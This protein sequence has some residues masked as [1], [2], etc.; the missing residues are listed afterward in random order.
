MG[1]YGLM[2][3][4]SGLEPAQCYYIQTPTDRGF[5]NSTNLVTTEAGLS[6][7][8]IG[9]TLEYIGGHQLLKDYSAFLLAMALTSQPS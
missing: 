8:P 2:W 3:V 4:N 1:R 5:T 7:V 6:L 9:F